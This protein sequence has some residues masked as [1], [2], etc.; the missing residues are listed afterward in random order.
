MLKVS[1]PTD[2][3]SIFAAIRSREVAADGIPRVG[4]EFIGNRWP[5]NR[6]VEPGSNG[7]P[8]KS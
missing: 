3:I 7:H 4:L 5:L 1:S 6:E 2:G 8:E